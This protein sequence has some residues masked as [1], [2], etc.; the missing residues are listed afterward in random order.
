LEVIGIDIADEAIRR[1]NV[2]IGREGL[3]ERARAVVMN[4]ESLD[5]AEAS[6]DI[7]C[8]AGVLHHLDVAK[9][10]HSWSRAL[11]PSGKVAMLEPM[12]WHPAVALYRVLT[13]N[14]RTPDEHPLKPEDIKILRAHFRSVR[15]RG[16]VLTSVATVLFTLWPGATRVRHAALRFLESLDDRLL[17]WFPFLVYFCWT[18]VI[19][20]SEPIQRRS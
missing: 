6:V 13:P 12:A 19:E 11:R 3:S 1:L 4:A 16:Y 15:M 7:I 20:L 17:R 18:C 5:V 8:C 14:M 10:A 9:A 2:A